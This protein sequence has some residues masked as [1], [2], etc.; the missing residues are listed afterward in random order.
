[1]SWW[2]GGFRPTKGITME[3]TRELR[4][5]W[6]ANRQLEQGS[7]DQVPAWQRAAPKRHAPYGVLEMAVRHPR[8]FEGL[9]AAARML[10]R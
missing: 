6:E 3:T 9:V 5:E 4:S 10:V 2:H 8:L 7:G 1:V